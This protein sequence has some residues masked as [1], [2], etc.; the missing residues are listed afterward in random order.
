MS[1]IHAVDSSP[2]LNIREKM[3]GVAAYSCANCTK[4]MVGKLWGRKREKSKGT[5]IGNNPNF[6]FKKGTPSLRF[7]DRQAVSF[8][9][10][11]L[12]VPKTGPLMRE[13]CVEVYARY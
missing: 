1:S 3:E 8:Q 2:L 13:H 6:F 11:N 7:E 9:V 4:R 12:L 5:V 10:V